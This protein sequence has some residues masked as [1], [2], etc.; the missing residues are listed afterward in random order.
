M[1]S[2]TFSLLEEAA[3]DFWAKQVK[4]L[5]GGGQGEAPVP[6]AGG[7]QQD[8]PLLLLPPRQEARPPPQ[9]EDRRLLAL[10][11]R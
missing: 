5:V 8:P 1:L 9:Q 3:V 11:L 7:E 10:P 6:E 4:E 2:V